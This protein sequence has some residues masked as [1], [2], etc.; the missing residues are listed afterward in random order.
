MLIFSISDK[1]ILSITNI[2]LVIAL[3][4]TLW[5]Y[6]PSF[7][8]HFVNWD[9]D[10]Y[11]VL[12]PTIRSFHNWKDLLWTD[13]QGNYHPLTMFSLALNYAISGEDAW[14]YHTFNIL[15]HLLNVLL[16]FVFIQKIT[17]GKYWISFVTAALFGIHPMHVESVAWITERKDVLYACFFLLGLST[18]W[19]YLQTK[20]L[21]YF[22]LTFICLLLSLLSKPAAVVFP[23][24]LLLLDYY[25]GREKEIQAYWE[26]I[27]FFLLAAAFAYLTYSAQKA[28]GS[29]VDTEVISRFYSIFFG[30][31][32][33]MMYF[34]KAVFPSNLA[35][36]HPFPETT[37]ALPYI[38]Y[39]SPLFAL[40][41]LLCVLFLWKKNRIVVWSIL[42]YIVN[43][44][45]VCQFLSIGSAVISE[46]YTYI[47]YIGLFFLLGQ[48]IQFVLEKGNLYLNRLL[49]GVGILSLLFLTYLC[50]EQ[51]KTWQDGGTLWE[52]AIRAEPTSRACVNRALISIERNKLADA[53]Y[54]YT[55]AVNMS[56]NDNETLN[57]R[58][59]VYFD[60]G[61]YSLAFADY[62]ASLAIQSDYSVAWDNLGALYVKWEQPDSAIVCFS[63][64][65]AIDSTYLI[66][67][68]NRA[69]TN[70][71]L[72]NYDLALADFNTYNRMNQ[73]PD[74][75]VLNSIALCYQAQKVHNR[76]I[77]ALDSAIQLKE[78]PVFYLNRAFS[79]ASL[80]K[81][82]EAQTDVEKAAEWDEKPDS[83]LQHLLQSKTDL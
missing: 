34:V 51:V 57:N 49:F 22:S 13:M 48:G 29:L 20:S 82:K 42:F 33:I 16:V 61:M 25:K 74:A 65:I 24:V 47:P 46:R 9:D 72:N 79:L 76:A 11:V 18:Y 27:P 30:F 43:L 40:F 83:L 31:Y 68:Y 54:F 62:K 52:Q 32:A 53:I 38:Y 37:E 69:V 75:D 3:L 60:L 67:Y 78:H 15:I 17:G 63:R 81:Q 77:L 36:F 56:P 23:L 7:S 12:N 64:A 28:Q 80:G 41:L 71:E 70:L 39:L 10:E 19:E 45:L 55:K 4:L 26:K 44:L 66:S 8:A 50:R 5:A 21:T 6:I 59:N 14:S 58:G 2:L 1:K 73:E 35:T